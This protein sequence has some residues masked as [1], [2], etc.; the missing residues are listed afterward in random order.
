M[1]AKEIKIKNLKKQREFIRKQ[2]ANAAAMEDGDISYVYIGYIFSEVVE[3][4][5][6]EGFKVERIE[7]KLPIPLAKGR[8]A[9][10]FT[11]NDDIELTKEE[12]EEAEVYELE[13]PE[14]P[15]DSIESLLDCLI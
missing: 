9:Y 5:E 10:L 2:L 3:Y 14:E 15:E 13:E 11:I 1:L 8:P 12:L 4:F 7:D 6:N